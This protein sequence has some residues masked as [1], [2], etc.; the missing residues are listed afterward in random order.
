MS[1]LAFLHHSGQYFSIGS[2]GYQFYC[3]GKPCQYVSDPTYGWLPGGS[4]VFIPAPTISGERRSAKPVGSLTIAPPEGLPNAWYY[5]PMPITLEDDGDFPGLGTAISHIFKVRNVWQIQGISEP[6]YYQVSVNS[7][8]RKVRQALINSWVQMDG[9]ISFQGSRWVSLGGIIMDREYDLAPGKLPAG[10]FCKTQMPNADWPDRSCLQTV[11]HPTYGSRTFII[12]STAN[13][14]WNCWPVGLTLDASLAAKSPYADQVDKVNLSYGYKTVSWPYPNWVYHPPTQWRD[15]LKSRDGFPPLYP[16]ITWSFNST[17]TKAIAVMIER[18]PWTGQLWTIDTTDSPATEKIN[19]SAPIRINTEKYIYKY[20]DGEPT[21]LFEDW[22]G[23]IELTFSITL[24]GSGLTEFTFSVSVSDDQPPSSVSPQ[25]IA[26]AYA[27]PV[28]WDSQAISLSTDERILAK[29]Y[30]YRH[31][32]EDRYLK[33]M[34]GVSISE[35]PIQAKLNLETNSQTLASIPLLGLT[36]ATVHCCGT[37]FVDETI[38]YHTTLGHLHLPTLSYTLVAKARREWL[39]TTAQ[40]T[41]LDVAIPGYSIP[42][43][44]RLKLAEL[45]QI[46]RTV[47]FGKVINEVNE[48]VNPALASNWL[49]TT[50]YPSADEHLIELSESYDLRGV[51]SNNNRG[52]TDPWW[53]SNDCLSAIR[54]EFYRRYYAQYYWADDTDSQHAAADHLRDLERQR[55]TLLSGITAENF[56]ETFLTPLLSHKWGTHLYPPWPDSRDGEGFVHHGGIYDPLPDPYPGTQRFTASYVPLDIENADWRLAI[57]EQLYTIVDRARALI[58]SWITNGVFT[59]NPSSPSNAADDKFFLDYAL[60]KASIYHRGQSRDSVTPL[61]VSNLP[62]GTAWRLTPFASGLT[63]YLHTKQICIQTDQLFGAVITHPLGHVSVCWR[64]PPCPKIKFPLYSVWTIDSDLSGRT[65]DN[66]WSTAIGNPLGLPSSG[67]F[68]QSFI[69]HISWFHGLHQTTHLDAY[70]SAFNQTLTSSDILHTVDTKIWDDELMVGPI[71][72]PGQYQALHSLGTWTY[73]KVPVNDDAY[74][75]ER[76]DQWIEPR[77]SP[78][79]F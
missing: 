77:L 42:E 22:L 35:F 6:V 48:G 19:T 44:K 56:D 73:S 49:N 68:D 60:N 32:D 5:E 40:E 18:R 21:A 30:C 64:T 4:G 2:H 12:L 17:G 61:S 26:V 71:I 69:D 20:K 37:E 16:R 63:A 31:N 34:G 57:C 36:G 38:T 62:S 25:I 15:A 45:G 50:V 14:A 11:T 53:F 29:M 23:L 24:T 1:G 33:S 51:N 79:F 65:F 47:A 58:T 75:Y 54:I 28:D 76:F 8:G 7:A 74:Y 13:G 78:L 39:D 9:I 59:P 67:W 43:T 52:S 70:N 72:R 41:R 27:A 66:D 10:G 3:T 55:G 46:S